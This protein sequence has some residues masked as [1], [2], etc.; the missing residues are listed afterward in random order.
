ML[1]ARGTQQDLSGSEHASSQKHKRSKFA[2]V[3]STTS[4]VVF[5]S[6]LVSLCILRNIQNFAF[7]YERDAGLLQNLLEQRFVQCVTGL[8]QTTK[9]ATPLSLAIGMRWNRI[10]IRAAPGVIINYSKFER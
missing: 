1:A 9:H 6:H 8:G 4:K 7:R 10:T 3:L 5:E 2:L